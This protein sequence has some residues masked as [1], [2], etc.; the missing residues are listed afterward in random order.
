MGRVVSVELSTDPIPDPVGDMSS[1]LF[2]QT[3]RVSPGAVLNSALLFHASYTV[4]SG[5]SSILRIG[6][7]ESRAVMSRAVA[8]RSLIGLG[9]IA[10]LTPLLAPVALA[11]ANYY[12]IEH[13]VPE[14]QRQGMWR[15]FSSALAGT[16]GIGSGGSSFV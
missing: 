16:V 15:G 11:A 10:P 13:K 12:V 3:I 4:S 8:G 6:P 1:F 7:L 2:D 5:L 9:T 14:E